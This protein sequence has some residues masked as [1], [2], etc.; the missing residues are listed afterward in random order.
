MA[1]ISPGNRPEAREKAL[2]LLL[3]F[4]YGAGCYALFRRAYMALAFQ[5][6]SP[7]HLLSSC[8][9][10]MNRATALANSLNSWL[11]DDVDLNGSDGHAF[12]ELI[13]DYFTAEDSSLPLAFK[14]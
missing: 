9:L 8:C 3:G 4:V 6:L 13:S 14:E 12:S 11:Q 10:K 2:S 7:K 5:V 1:V